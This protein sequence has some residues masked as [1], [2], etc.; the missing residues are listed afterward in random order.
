VRIDAQPDEACRA[1]A[2]ASVDAMVNGTCA[3]R[4]GGDCV[5]ERAPA[6]LRCDTRGR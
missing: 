4:V 6:A 5:G 2:Q 3:I 1:L